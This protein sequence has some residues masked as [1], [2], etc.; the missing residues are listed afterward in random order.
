MMMNNDQTL[1]VRAEHQQLKSELSQ[2]VV[3][4]DKYV[5]ELGYGA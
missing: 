2:L 1:T 4:M 5:K 3:E